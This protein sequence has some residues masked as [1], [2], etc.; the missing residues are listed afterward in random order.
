MTV[1]EPIYTGEVDELGNPE[2]SHWERVELLD[3]LPEP[4]LPGDKAEA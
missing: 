2:I 3:A 1:D 4:E